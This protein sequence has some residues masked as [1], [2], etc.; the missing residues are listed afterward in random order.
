MDVGRARQIALPSPQMQSVIKPID[1]HS[2]PELLQVG[3]LPSKQLIVH[4][5]DFG[6][7]AKQF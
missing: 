1:R 5:M 3:Q 4:E 7:N 6:I 2:F